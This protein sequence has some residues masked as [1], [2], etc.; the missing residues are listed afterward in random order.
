MLDLLAYHFCDLFQGSIFDLGQAEVHP[1]CA[2]GARWEP[3]V[4]VLWS[5]VEGF[6]ID[7]VWRGKGCEPGAS[8]AHC[9]S[10]AESVAAQTL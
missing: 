2:H 10:E 1:D 8:E 5:P 7:E 4:P 9:G 3:D 6:R